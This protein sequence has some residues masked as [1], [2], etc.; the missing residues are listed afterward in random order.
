MIAAI[1]G[2]PEVMITAPRSEFELSVVM[3]VYNEADAVGPVVSAWA[4]E[5]D[6][7]KIR[8]ELLVYDDGS[9]DRTADVLRR[10][11]SGRHQVVVKSHANMGHGPTISRGYREAAGE[12]VFQID[13][14][15]EMSPDGFE[16]LWTRRAAYDLLLGCRQDRNSTAARRIISFGSR[17]IVRLLF[18]KGLWDVNTP[19]RLIR[20]SALA[21]MLTR[22]PARAFA[23]NVIMSGLAVRDG[24]RVYQVRV[25][26]QVR[27][28]GTASIAGWRQW[29]TA[30]RCATETA[31]VARRERAAGRRTVSVEHGD[32]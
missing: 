18:G 1:M 5:L 16:Q 8:Y 29:R 4:E 27:R 3:P 30:L 11:A 17:A 25:P 10:I 12:W 19:Y 22:I 23:P 2:A 21:A 32:D 28:A 7:L 14:D 26:H 9:R 13:S 6:R 20:R 24:L 15:D 31:S